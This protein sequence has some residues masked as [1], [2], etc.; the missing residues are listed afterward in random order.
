MNARESV[1]YL[2]GIEHALNSI[3]NELE[4]GHELG[5]ILIAMRTIINRRKMP[6]VQL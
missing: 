2:Y 1:W 6:E 5:D 4:H 3:V